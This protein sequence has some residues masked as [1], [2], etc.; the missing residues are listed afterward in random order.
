MCLTKRDVPLKVVDD[1][2][3]V[4]LVAPKEVLDKQ[5]LEIYELEEEVDKIV[6]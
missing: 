6:K 3:K 1:V 2:F 4:C 5:L